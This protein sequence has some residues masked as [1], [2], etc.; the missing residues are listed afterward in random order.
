[1][2]T[3][4]QASDSGPIFLVAPVTPAINDRGAVAFR[5]DSFD[6]VNFVQAIFVGDHRSLTPVVQSSGPGSPVN[7]MSGGTPSISNRDTVA[8]F[9]DACSSDPAI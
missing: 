4:L 8:F 1:M 2:T 3:I 6:G 9:C 5:A 7:F